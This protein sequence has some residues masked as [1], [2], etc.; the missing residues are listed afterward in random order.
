M[1]NRNSYKKGTCRQFRVVEKYGNRVRYD[2]NND[3]EIFP[4][5]LIQ[6]IQ[7]TKGHAT[8]IIVVNSFLI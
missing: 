4:H 2:S 5:V 1:E 7:C 8:F 6:F 3:V